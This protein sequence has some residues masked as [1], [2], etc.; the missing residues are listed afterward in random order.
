MNTI[1]KRIRAL[2]LDKKMTQLELARLLKTT[3]D[4][5]SLWEK[6]KRL[7]TTQ[8]LIE[9]TKI[10]KVSADYLLGL[11]DEYGTKLYINNSFNNINGSNNFK[12][13]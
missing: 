12:I 11:E 9:L 5:I 1:G 13:K 4:S 10:L 8:N 7:P 3:Q 2:R 6:D